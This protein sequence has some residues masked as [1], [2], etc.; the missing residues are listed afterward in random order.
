MIQL[1]LKVKN[2]TLHGIIL[3]HVT[4]LFKSMALFINI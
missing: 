4:L 2:L 1:D 3:F